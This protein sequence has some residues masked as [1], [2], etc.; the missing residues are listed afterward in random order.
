MVFYAALIISMLFTLVLIPPLVKYADVIGAIDK[1]NARKVHS[2]VIPRIG[3][4]AMILGAFVPM[5]IW[6]PLDK[7]YLS[8]LA[9]VLV[10]F[11]FG[12]WDDRKEIS[13]KF[14]FLGQFVA[15]LIV[16]VVGDISVKHVPF[17]SDMAI[18]V[19]VS[20]CFTI[21][22][23]L[24]ITNAL[25]LADGLDGLAG[26][27]TLLSFGLIGILSLNSDA[28]YV[29]MVTMSVVGCVLGFL[30]FNSHPAVIFMGDTGSQFLGFILGVQMI[31][32]TQSADLALSKTLPLLMLGLPL[33]DTLTVML[34][35]M[36]EGRSPFTPDKNHLH[37][38]LLALGFSHYETVVILYLIQSVFVVSAFLTCYS[39]DWIPALLFAVYVMALL[40]T[41]NYLEKNNAKL[42]SFG[43]I[44]ALVKAQRNWM[45]KQLQIVNIEKYTVFY[46]ALVVLV[47]TFYSLTF[48]A[49]YSA[50]IQTLP[51]ILSIVFAL[52]IFSKTIRIWVDRA[53]AYTFCAL[54]AYLGYGNHA[55]FEAF[56]YLEWGLVV[57]SALWIF[58]IIPLQNA[59]KFETS[60]FDILI[61]LLSLLI[62]YF[63]EEA[64]KIDRLAV[65]IIKFMVLLYLFEYVLS[66]NAFHSR[67][68][69]PGV[70]LICSIALTFRFIF[71]D[72]F[73]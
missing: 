43:S 5:L 35:R 12:I 47:L 17:L 65:N 63:A 37:H 1:P 39:A 53:A 2:N 24:A 72:T 34:K 30:R 31:L 27:T 19:I 38:R 25:N 32:L 50:D 7:Q 26:G 29:L 23:L 54:L 61:V 51:I 66:R 44:S 8:I 69:L 67:K 18:P 68:N 41:L 40:A 52:S 13:Y 33:L 21:L 4:I 73:L 42:S 59:S 14:K 16:V 45:A 46:V 36:L 10:I 71:T 11:G 57:A 56:Y 49:S 20:Q 64:S 62:P 15:S 55:Q 3:G 60:P 22:C 48:E 70:L 58:V 9:G 28:P 6:L